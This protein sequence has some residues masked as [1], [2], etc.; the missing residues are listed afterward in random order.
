MKIE[1]KSRNLDIPFKK[2][3]DGDVFRYNVGCFK[4][5]I[6]MKLPLLKDEDDESYNA[7]N[8]TSNLLVWFSEEEMIQPFYETKLVIG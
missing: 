2:L 6:Y 3:K 4:D 1:F 8:L 7:F 5:E